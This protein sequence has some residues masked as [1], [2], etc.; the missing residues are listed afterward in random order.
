VEILGRGRIHFFEEPQ[1][2]VSEEDLDDHGGCRSPEDFG[3][4]AEEQ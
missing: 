2:L 4:K 3:R 1:V